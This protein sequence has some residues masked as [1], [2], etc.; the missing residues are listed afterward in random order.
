MNLN[1]I[2][3]MSTE[4]IQVTVND[5]PLEVVSEYVYLGHKIQLG[6]ENQSSEITR[7][8]G[9]SWA[10]F[11]RLGFILKSSEFPINLKRRVFDA[12]VTPVLTYGLETIV[13]QLKWSFTLN[14]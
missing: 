9:L 12:C 7:R 8:M 10:A 4:D 5:Q 3:I 11:G 6:K 1:K 2:K 13:A 14:N